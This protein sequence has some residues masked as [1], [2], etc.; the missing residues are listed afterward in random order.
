MGLEKKGMERADLG[1]VQD[2]LN[3]FL[4]TD[5]TIKKQ[6]RAINPTEDTNTPLEQRLRLT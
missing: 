5:I 6:F 3:Q 4:D 2:K 1:R